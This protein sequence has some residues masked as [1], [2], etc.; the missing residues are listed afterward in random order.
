MID[1]QG[2]PRGVRSAVRVGPT[3]VGMGVFA[4]RCFVAGEEILRFRGRIIDFP[5]TLA[6]G[7]RECNAFQIGPDAYLDPVGPGVFVNHSCDPNAGIRDTTR[8]VALRDLAADEEVRFDYSTTMDESHW[9]MACRCGSRRC[10]RTIGDFKLLP[11]RSK[12]R[13]LRLNV[14]PGFI[15]ES[16]LRAGSLRPQD[17]NGARAG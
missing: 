12:L 9:T 16:E 17:L 4:S 14:V 15:I 7:L 6:M 13:L 1:G 2:S 5:S 10:R 3:D 8:L 11:R